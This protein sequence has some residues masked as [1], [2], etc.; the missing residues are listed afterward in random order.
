M[1]FAVHFHVA[2]SLAS[3]DRFNFSINPRSSEERFTSSGYALPNDD[4]GADKKTSTVEKKK[5]AS[6]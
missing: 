6:S 1:L 4:E 3:C 5:A 2:G